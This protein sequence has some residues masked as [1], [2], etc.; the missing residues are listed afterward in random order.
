[1]SDV[2]IPSTDWLRLRGKKLFF[3]PAIHRAYVDGQ[4]TQAD[5]VGATESGNVTAPVA[6]DACHLVPLSHDKAL[7]VAERFLTLRKVQAEPKSEIRAAV[8]RV[9]SFD[10]LFSEKAMAAVGITQVDLAAASGLHQRTLENFLHNGRVTAHVLKAL[11]EGYQ[12]L[13]KKAAD[14]P[15]HMQAFADAADPEPYVTTDYTVPHTAVV[16]DERGE[17]LRHIDDMGRAPAGWTKWD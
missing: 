1:M 4:L 6:R 14:L 3:V 16:K 13:L 9:A 8:F 11:L 7:L 10:D 17:Y 2:S 12:G 5:L 15:E